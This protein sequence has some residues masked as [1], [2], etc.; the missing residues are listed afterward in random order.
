MA[1]AVVHT[2]PSFAAVG[3][4]NA[5]APVMA[6]RGENER[7]DNDVV[8]EEGDVPEEDFPPPPP[9]PPPRPWS[10]A[11]TPPSSPPPSPAPLLLLPVRHEISAR[12]TAAVVVVVAAAAPA[13]AAAVAAVTATGKCVNTQRQQTSRPFLAPSSSILFTAVAVATAAVS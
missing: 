7:T 10:S 12:T 5:A 13:E 4:I 1:I 3:I 11:K 6:L 9:P 2:T 8:S